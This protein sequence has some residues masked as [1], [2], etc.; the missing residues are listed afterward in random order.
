MNTRLVCL[1]ASIFILNINSLSAQY[2]KV[3]EEIVFQSK[4]DNPI[5]VEPIKQKDKYVFQASNRSFYPYQLVL[6]FEEIRNMYPDIPQYSFTVNPGTNRLLTLSVKD[7][8]NGH[9][10]KYSVSY[11][12]GVPSKNVVYDFPYLFPLGINSNFDLL[13]NVNDSKTLY[14]QDH[15]KIKSGDT[16]FNMRKGYVAAVPDMFNGADRI[17]A[18]KSLEIIHKDGTIMIYENIDPDKVFVKPGTTVY[19]G[20]ALG[21]INDDCILEL[22]LYQI[23]KDGK[24]ENMDI[25][26]FNGTKKAEPFS[27][28]L[29]NIKHERP[30][31]I[32]GREMSKREIKNKL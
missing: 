17:S 14:L 12:I 20:D 25:T 5:T 7:I 4:I 11:K 31:E 27:E 28:N 30:V 8:T 3:T 24:P 18:R 9:S 32:V 13:E 26:Y 19:P 16:I 22:Y 1:F 10:Y 21:I 29:R 15:F 2:Q 23:Q 6:K